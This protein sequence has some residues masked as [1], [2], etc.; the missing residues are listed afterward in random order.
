[1]WFLFA[2]AASVLWGMTYVLDERIYKHI[3]VLTSLAIGCAISAFILGITAF[4]T[5]DLKRDISTL[6]T[7]N[8]ALFFLL[9]GTATFI[10]AELLIGFSIQGKNATLAGLIEISYPLFIV[11][12]SY[13]FF[14]EMNLN[15]GTALGG[16]LIIAGVLSIYL[17]NR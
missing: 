9:A 7:S 13:I 17:F 4:M 10:A 5:G 3:S 8:Q 15:L 1:M 12:F 2:T 14:R 6:A 11:L 16:A